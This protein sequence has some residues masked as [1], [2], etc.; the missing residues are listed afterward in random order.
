MDERYACLPIQV[1][2]EGLMRTVPRPAPNEVRM[3]DANPLKFCFPLSSLLVAS[4]VCNPFQQATLSPHSQGGL[5]VLIN[6]KSQMH[7][8]MCM[9]GSLEISN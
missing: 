4:A 9:R 3:R 7:H 6:V 1:S 5:D 2:V 8:P